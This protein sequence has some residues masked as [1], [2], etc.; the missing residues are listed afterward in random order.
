MK[1]DAF[2]LRVRLQTVALFLITSKLISRPSI[3]RLI[4]PSKKQKKLGTQPLWAQ[5]TGLAG[6]N[7][8]VKTL[9]SMNCTVTNKIL[10]SYSMSSI[11]KPD[12][13]FAARGEMIQSAR[14][15]NCGTL[16]SN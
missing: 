2:Q 8:T 14:H 13:T 11:I 3:L 10:S 1:R 15:F 9:P 5:K 12:S 16:L 4:G 7:L 6:V